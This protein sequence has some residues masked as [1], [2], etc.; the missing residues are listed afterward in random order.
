MDTRTE[1]D[2]L[3]EVEVPAKAY[4]GAQT[5]RAVH[6]FPI[7]GLA[8][9]PTLVRAYAFL[10]RAAASV[11]AELGLLDRRRADAVVQAA[12]EILAGRLADQFVVDP[13]Q[14][15]AGTSHHMNVNEVLANRANEILGGAKGT[16]DPVHP[17]NHVN[18]G[19]ST[20]DTFPTAM[21]IAVLLIEG[22][23]E[24]ILDDLAQ[25]F[26]DKGHEFKDLVTAGRT[27][28]QDA[29]PITLGQVFD[30]YAE[31]L[32]RTRRDLGTASEALEELGIGGTAVG[33]GVNR[34]PDY[35]A[36]ICA[37]LSRLTGLSLH[38]TDTPLAMHPSM[39]DFAR[40][41]GALKGV[42]LEM[43][44]I[45]NDLRLM[46]SGPTS[47]IGEI[48]LP[49]VQPGSSIMPGKVNPVMAE[50]MNMVCNHVIGSETAV[51]MASQAGQ[52]QLN[53]MMP[54]IAY[55]VLFS[56]GILSRALRVFRE[57]CVE[58]IEA[59]PEVCR[60]YAEGTVS[61]A[62]VL[63]PVVGYGKA[64]EIV[65]RAVAEKRSVIAVAAEV[66]AIPEAAARELLD[67]IRWT[68][69]GIID[70]DSVKLEGD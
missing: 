24:K 70:K 29:T 4:W 10:K 54:V 49:A 52:F 9:D 59:D 23:L 35:P 31:A 5:Q 12:D 21:R 6:N 22:E 38:P 18:F 51:A 33:T 66:L 69:P 57:R 34:H 44:R 14:A 47:G 41:A 15:G 58:G 37:E 61:L 36:E 42:A 27:H 55:E 17:N 43:T 26:H 64:A 25:A 19:Q 30:G 46:S 68:E 3:G 28:L 8:P 45:A 40:Y 53:V 11:N 65:K 32:R 7:S 50:N 60:A 39:H 63:N 56:M 2:S 1:R 13:F 16:Y 62:T 48:V 67:P 20:N